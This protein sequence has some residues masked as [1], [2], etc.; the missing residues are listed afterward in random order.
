MVE[1][2]RVCTEH[3]ESVTLPTGM[4]DAWTVSRPHIQEDA[5]LRTCRHEMRAALM[6]AIGRAT[7][8]PHG[9][10]G[11]EMARMLR[12][13]WIALDGNHPG[14]IYELRKVIAGVWRGTE[15]AGVGKTMKK[16]Y[17]CDS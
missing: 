11:T 4:W 1:P 8:V 9:M 17:S 2:S 7:S 12:G 10:A 5:E 13:A 16:E 15:H 14:W 6:R 3:D